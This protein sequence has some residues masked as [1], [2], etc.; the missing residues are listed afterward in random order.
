MV[1][2]HG[3]GCKY[4]LRLELHSCNISM[5]LKYAR[6]NASTWRNAK[7]TRWRELHGAFHS[8]DIEY[9]EM[10]IEWPNDTIM[11]LEVI[12]KAHVLVRRCLILKAVEPHYDKE[13]KLWFSRIIEELVL[14]VFGWLW[15]YLG[16]D[17]RIW[18]VL[19]GEALSCDCY[20]RA[21]LETLTN[22]EPLLV[23]K[24]MS[25]YHG[26]WCIPNSHW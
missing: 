10:V 4:L 13:R 17:H 23:W 7:S 19:R 25:L 2:S 3:L 24:S 15:L 1:V 8:E 11:E 16:D 9:S 14:R 18:I 5:I 6:E 22:Y 12:Y 21:I 26:K 20:H